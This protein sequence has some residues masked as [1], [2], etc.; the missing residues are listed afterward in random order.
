M[1]RRH[2]SRHIKGPIP[3]RLL[4]RTVHVQ[5]EMQ[6]EIH[7][8]VVFWGYEKAG[9]LV[10]VM[11]IQQRLP[12]RASSKAAMFTIDWTVINP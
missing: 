4:D 11:G 2:I 6:D 5:G 8:G 10:D 1:A 12:Y 7:E 3:S 9:A